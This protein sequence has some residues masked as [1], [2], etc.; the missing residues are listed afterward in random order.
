MAQDVFKPRGATKASQPGAGGAVVR[1]TPM[2]GIVKD[3]I[4]PIRAGR[5]RVY[6]A[7]LGG[8]DPDDSNS[9]ITVGYMSPFFGETKGNGPATGYGDYSKN[10][11]SYGMWI[12]PPDIG[13]T[14]VC[15]FINGDSN[16]GY[17]IGCVPN[18]E[19]LYMVPAIGSYENVILNANEAKSYGGATRLPVANMNTNDSG[20][21]DSPSFVTSPRP[22]HSYSASVYMQQGLLRDPIRGPISSSSQRETPSRVGWG[23]NTPGRPIYEGGFTDENITQKALEPGQDNNLKITSRRAG[24]SIV[25]DD[26]D[27]LGR[28]QLIRLRSSL[29]HQILLS[30]NGQCVHIIHANG[31]SWIELGKEGTIDMYSTNSVNIRTQGDLNLH[32]DNNININANKQLNL[33][34]ETININSDKDTNHKIGGKYSIFTQANYT[35][36]V[37]GAMSM[38]ASGVASYASTDVTYINGSKVNLN[39]GSSSVI[40]EE[41]K[42]VP[43]VAHTD[44]LNDPI[45]GW[46]AAPGKL[47]S[48]VSRAPAHAPWADAGLG[49]DVKTSGNADEALPQNPS[50]VVEKTNNSDIVTT[51]QVPGVNS[52]IISTV[53][54]VPAISNAVDKNTT[55]ALV[56]Q[57]AALAATGIAKDAVK[58]GQGI[59]ETVSGKVAALGAFAQTP[60]QLEAAGILK[61][62]SSQLVDALVKGG[63]PLDQALTENLFTGKPGAETLQKFANNTAVQVQAQVTNLQQAQTALTNIGLITGKESPTQLG[64]LLM[65]AATQGVQ[66]TAKFAQDVA[67]GVSNVIS[68]PSK[69]VNTLLGPVQKTMAAG[70]IA[71]NVAA[72]V[73]GGLS[74]LA[75]ALGGK[76]LSKV[77]SLAGLADAA[78]GISASA[79]KTITSGFPT[80]AAGVPQ[81]IKQITN[82]AQQALGNMSKGPAGLAS[83]ASGLNAIPGAEKTVASVVSKATGAINAIPGVSSITSAIQNPQGIINQLKSGATSLTKLAASGLPTAQLAQLNSAITSLS[84]GGSVNIQLPKIATDTFSRGS[85]TALMSSTMFNPKIPIPNYS[86]NPATFGSTPGT[87]ALD[88]A[89]AKADQYSALTKQISLATDEMLNARIEYNNAQNDLPEGSPEI[90]R[91]RQNLK[92]SRQRL[93]DLLKQAEQFS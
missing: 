25:M 80:L 8:E 3:N 42:Q 79:F 72:T 90:E 7:D 55:S 18:P 47:L 5:I 51:T 27:A 78:K 16:Y 53:P 17:Y 11:V 28:D 85:L 66:N 38:A 40:P 30:D 82:A 31:Q 29:G 20:M 60:I 56:G 48:I 45:K 87:E 54:S 1:T 52:A 33:N 88:Q 89:K 81:N 13:S 34:A 76:G 19:T 59:V 49:I 50:T 2:L 24:H 14:V 37:S 26:G 73:T 69:A 43:I 70:N 36:K 62:G 93:E 63:K 68:D 44:T 32:A 83:L 71:T 39:T 41:V 67:S 64:G 86:G 10:P 21:V 35:V 77:T 23:V 84:S 9:W 61:P 57:T 65:S 58:A 75:G 6:L 46:A 12:S 15:I 22:V 4:D 92:D 91:L 74:S